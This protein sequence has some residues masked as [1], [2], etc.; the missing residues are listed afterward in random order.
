MVKGT[1]ARWFGPRSQRAPRDD[2]RIRLS[3]RER[4][5]LGAFPPRLLSTFCDVATGD[6]IFLDLPEHQPVFSVFSSVPLVS[7]SN[8]QRRPISNANW[9]GT[10]HGLPIS[11][12]TPRPVG[13]SY[14]AFL[15][16]ISPE[17]AVDRAIRIAERCGLP[18]KIAAKID[19]ADQDYFDETIRP[20]L[21]PNVDFIGAI[22][23]AQKSDFLSG[24]L[25][26]L[27]ANRLAGALW[28]GQ[29]G[30]CVQPRFRAGS[31]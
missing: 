28:P 29:S 5:R 16:R 21:K 25:A 24:A 4:L 14:L 10:V 9:I 7:I 15:G 20:L 27:R 23:D 13:P 18:I 2:G 30:D 3:A 1:P 26:L 6:A 22:T 17:K 8:S 11:L 12:L 31:D 19:A